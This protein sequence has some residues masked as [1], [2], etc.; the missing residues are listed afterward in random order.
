MTTLSLV[1]DPHT[2]LISAIRNLVCPLCGGSMMEFRCLGVCRGNWRQEWER[3]S[4]K[5]KRTQNAV[6]ENAG[7]KGAIRASARFCAR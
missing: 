1:P 7:K 5:A 6:Y 2:T 4:E 3:R